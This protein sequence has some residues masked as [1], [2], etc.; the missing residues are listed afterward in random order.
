MKDQLTITLKDE[1]KKQFDLKMKNIKS[2]YEQQVKTLKQKNKEFL[3]NNPKLNPKI[4][5]YLTKI[6]KL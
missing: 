3:I 4:E 5:E 6:E 1:L 2:E